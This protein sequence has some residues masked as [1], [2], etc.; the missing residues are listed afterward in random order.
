MKNL[1]D[2]KIAYYTGDLNDPLGNIRIFNLTPHDLNVVTEDGS[3]ETLPR[4]GLIARVKQIDKLDG[5]IGLI[6]ITKREFGEVEDLPEP[7]DS[8]YFIVSSLVA[9]AAKGRDDL[10]VPGPTST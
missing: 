4:S 5:A 2:L 7:V 1:E 3:V 6:N 10:L 9:S 8:V